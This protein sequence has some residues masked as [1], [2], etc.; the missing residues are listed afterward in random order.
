V[1][2]GDLMVVMNALRSTGYLKIA[3]VGLQS[4]EQH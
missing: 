1:S 2:Y 3:L 4:D